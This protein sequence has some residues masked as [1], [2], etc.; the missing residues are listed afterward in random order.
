MAGSLDD[1]R[2][3][4]KYFEPWYT[5]QGDIYSSTVVNLSDFRQLLNIV[6]DCHQWQQ[7]SSERTE[8]RNKQSLTP[9]LRSGQPLNGTCFVLR[10]QNM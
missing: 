2:S 3:R 9:K 7:E 1:R 8:P 10:N 4:R 6:S 5:D